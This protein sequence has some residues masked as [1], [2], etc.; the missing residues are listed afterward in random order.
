MKFITQR[1]AVLEMAFI[2]GV[3][4]EDPYNAVDLDVPFTSPSGKTFTVPGFWA[5]GNVWKVRFA[6][7]ETGEYQYETSAPNAHDPGLHGQSGSISVQEYVGENSL[8]RHGRLRVAEDKRH[9]ELADGTPFFWT[10]DT[11][12]MGLCTRLDWPEGFKELAADR[13]AK[14]FNVIQ[15]IAGPYPDMDEWDPRGRNEAGFSFTD[16]Y[17]SINPAYYDHA[18]LKIAHLVQQGLMPCIVGMWGYYLPRMGVDKAKRFWRYL[19][20][21][22]GAY[23][24]TW[25][26]CGEG[27]MAY[28][29]SETREADIEAQKSGWTEVMRY[30]R[31]SDGY[32]NLLTIHPTQ[33]GREQVTDPSVMDY[34]MLQTGHGDIESVPNT[35]DSVRKAVAVTPSMPVVLS[36]VNY[37]GILGRAWQNVQRLCFYHAALNGAAGF[38]YGANGIWQLNMD[39]A[40]YGPSP[41]G[42]SWGDTPWREAARLPGSAQ[43]GHGGAFMARFPWWELRPQ[44]AWVEGANKDNDA[45][46]TVSTGKPGELR[47]VY[48]PMCWNAPVLH[49]LENGVAWRAYYFDPCTGEDIPLPTLD[50]KDG[51]WTP[52]FPPSVHD[53][54]LVLDARA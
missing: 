27:A 26:A 15:I 25:C 10:G 53:W 38:T 47:I 22:Y 37:E 52:P 42:R 8:L 43:V 4:H 19:I 40:P 17:A 3:A 23:P 44:D 16:G 30:I 33:Y 29:L 12:W 11:W 41:H 31:E 1:N 45:Y 46:T 50:I 35:I 51:A 54:L 24:V 34:E 32:G 9:F 5:G 21:R 49:G 20:A 36:E 7:D 14:G 2:C 48:V 6:G 39:H 18:D 13:V 28:Y